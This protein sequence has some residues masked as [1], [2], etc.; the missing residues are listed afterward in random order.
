MSAD[1]LS[2]D[3]SFSESDQEPENPEISE[4]DLSL[5]QVNEMVREYEKE[6]KKERKTRWD[7]GVAKQVT[8]DPERISELKITK[9][10]Y[11]KL[12]PNERTLKQ[13]EAFKVVQER[14]PNKPGV[15]RVDLR[16]D[17]EK[18]GIVLNVEPV[19]KR[20]PKP[21]PKPEPIPEPE[22]EEEEI[23]LPK[24][25]GFQGRKPKLDDI[26]EKVQKLEKLNKVIESANPWYAQIMASRNKTKK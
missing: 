1:D 6:Q 12:I 3:S 26:D 10:Q 9:R 13:Q 25:R 22:E 23:E 19:K 16:K 2:S 4:S 17:Q 8:I 11:K 14:C 18:P 15:K 7:K 21:K 5:L 20:V 24:P